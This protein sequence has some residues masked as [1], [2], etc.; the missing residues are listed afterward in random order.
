MYVIWS[1]A[2]G[3]AE[4]VVALLAEHLDRV[5]YRPL[6]VCLNEE[7]ALAAPLR[8]AGVEI[9]ALRKRGPA[10]L[11]T[12]W[13]LVSLMRQ[14]RVQLVHTHLWGANLWGRLAA[15]IA[16][17]PV[18]ATEHNT[19][20]WKPW[21][22]LLLDRWLAPRTS[23]LIA[24]SQ[25][26]KDFYVAHGIGPDRLAVIPN[27]IETERFASVPPSG[28]YRELGWPEQAP[29]FLAIGRLVPA[30][31]HDRFIDAMAQVIAARPGARGLIIGEGPLQQTLAQ[32]I[33]ARGLQGQVVL[34]G[35]RHDVPSLLG[36]ARAVVFTSEREGLPMVTLEAMAAGVPVVST[37]VGG[38][39]EVIEDGRTGWL[40]PP[41]DE[42]SLVERLTRLVDEPALAQRA[43]A[44]AQTAVRGRWSLPAMVRAH[45]A[46]Y[47]RALRPLVPVTFIIDHLGAGGAQRQLF[48]LVSRLPKERFAARVISLSD[49]PQ[50]DLERFRAAGIEVACIAQ[51]GAWNWRCFWRL[52]RALRRQRPRIVHTWLFTADL[53]GRLAAR[54]AGVPVVV[55]AV[56]S[57]DAGKPGHYIA[58]DRWLGRMTNALTVNAEA[59]RRVLRDREGLPASKLHTIYNGVDLHVFNPATR[60]GTLR[61]QWRVGPADQVVGIVG[62]LA[63]EKDH[64]TFLRAAAAVAQQQPNARF[65]IVGQGPLRGQLEQLSRQLGL[66]PQ[67]RF[68]DSPQEIADVFA[69]IDLL[70]L[71]SIYEGCSNVILEAMAMGK[72]V[73]A[74]DV[75]GNPEL[76]EPQRTGLLVPV[77]NPEALAEAMVQLLRDPPR[78]TQLGEAGRQRVEEYF[79]AERMVAQ[80][81]SLYESLLQ[82]GVR[83]LLASKVSDTISGEG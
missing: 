11:Q 53:Y 31:R 64:A 83:H 54:L 59:I 74:T 47:Q 46:L 4:R 61:Q 19:D 70:V 41:D 22:Y 3:G 79:S 81:I 76:V 48:E 10:D 69:A 34:A 55:S 78:A 68:V 38:V 39:P 17:I 65:L 18:I 12:L 7:G 28:F 75:G 80:T 5:R 20:T 73:I 57:V 44:A 2:V 67:V 45:D 23:A 9:M 32:R 58:A 56:R 33:A 66:Q 8:Q 16:G 40:V 50:A 15:W 62:R 26:V 35:V 30:K 37:P 51:S 63:P 27:G 1:L 21:W 13:R 29:R 36:G 42:A 25:A 24:V 49:Q 72:P 82:K 71:S 77:G 43:G 60:N 6:V 52:L 14:Q